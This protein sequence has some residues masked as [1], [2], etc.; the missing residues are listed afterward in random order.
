M[1]TTDK[2]KL[3]AATANITASTIVMRDVNSD[4][5]ARYASLSY[6]YTVDDINTGAITNIMA[7][8]GDHY[9]RSADAA[10]VLTFLG[11]TA[12][13]T[14]YSALDLSGANVLATLVTNNRG[15]V[16]SA[17]TRAMTLANLGYTGATN[18][19]YY[20]YTHPAYTAINSTLSGATVPATHV[21]DATGHTTG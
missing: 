18:A 3:D 2:I 7:K 13:T 10:K 1:V 16:I 9:H 12:P 15:Q 17:S 20:T 21:T 4:I 14:V 5:V 19:N 8:F 6:V 11:F